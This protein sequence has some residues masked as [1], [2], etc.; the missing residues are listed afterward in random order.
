MEYKADFNVQEF[1]FWSGAYD[2]VK[3]LTCAQKEQLGRYIETML[4]EDGMRTP[5][6]G[7]INEFVWFECDKFIAGLKGDEAGEEEE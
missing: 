5:T 6:N 1:K 7:E 3:D 4:G 2:R